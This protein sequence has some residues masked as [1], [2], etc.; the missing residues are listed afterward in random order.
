MPST[1]G[2][3]RSANFYLQTNTQTFQSPIN[4]TVQTAQLAGALWRFDCTLRKMTKKDAAKWIAFFLK[5]RGSSGTFNAYDPDW[6]APLGKGG[7]TPL[8]NGSGQTGTSLV[9]DGCTANVTGWLL[10]G[11]YFSTSSQ[12]CRL[13]QDANTNGSGQTTLVFESYLRT[14]PADN[15]AITITRPAVTM[16]LVDDNQL[17]WPTDYNG[18]YQEKTFSAYEAI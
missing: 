8:V 16:K 12:L 1:R 2:F 7:G 18:I 10:A 15:S 14:A 5:L 4:K 3:I 11:D 13:T 17:S 9:V 6:Q